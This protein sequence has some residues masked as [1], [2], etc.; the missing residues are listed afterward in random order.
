MKTSSH[1]LSEGGKLES[2][3]PNKFN[4]T[5]AML[6]LI[7]PPGRTRR[8]H[9]VSCYAVKISNKQKFSLCFDNC[10]TFSPKNKK[11]KQKQIQLPSEWKRN[12]EMK[13]SDGGIGFG[14]A[15]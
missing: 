14:R 11:R 15:D 5:C 10:A 4:P 9:S 1:A 2:C 13:S 3:F 7:Y 6:R 8:N 12:C